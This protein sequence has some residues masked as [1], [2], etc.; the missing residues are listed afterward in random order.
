VNAP[1]I[2]IRDQLTFCVVRAFTIDFP[3]PTLKINL[4]EHQIFHLFHFRKHID[5]FTNSIR[6]LFLKLLITMVITSAHF[7]KSNND[8]VNLMLRI[9]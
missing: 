1:R 8:N 6:K 2:V 3:T 9:K 5:L 4:N 7:Y